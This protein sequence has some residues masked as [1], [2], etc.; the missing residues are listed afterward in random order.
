MT[1]A[2]ISFT[3]KGKQIAERLY[4]SNPGQMEFQLF[5]KEKPDIFVRDNWGRPL[6]FIGA[7]GIAVRG[8]AP[9][10]KDKLT[11]SPVIVID[12]MGKYV[13]PI[14]SGHVGGANALAKKLA[15]LIEGEAVI[16]TATDI[17]RLFSVD[18]FAAQ[19]HM[20]IWNREGIAKVS[21]KLLEEGSITYRCMKEFTFTGVF[22]KELQA[23]SDKGDFG[24]SIFEKEKENVQLFLC[25][26]RLWLGIGCKKGVDAKCMEEFVIETLQIEGILWEA[27]C[28]VASIDLKKN[29]PAIL[30]LAEKWK[31]PFSYYTASDLQKVK[32]SVSTS[33]FVQE[34]TGVENVCE[35]AALLASA[36]ED[37]EGKLVLT[38]R[39]RDGMTLAAALDCTPFIV[40]K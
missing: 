32:G 15:D 5:H 40:E 2:V 39:A 27:V 8:I 37:A 19:N 25:P 35:R 10:V 36:G 23:T 38:K 3:L 4:N 22:P 30:A 34:I 7:V 13:I 26:P 18:V 17:N 6:V 20:K 11:D 24:I 31:I 16:T 1:I 14:L 12:E 9:M 33:A 21:G 29:E 28:G